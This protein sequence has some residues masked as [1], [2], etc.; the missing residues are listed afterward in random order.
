MSEDVALH[1]EGVGFLF[2][3][4]NSTGD[5]VDLAANEL[6]ATLPAL[7]LGERRLGRTFEGLRLAIG[8]LGL[9]QLVGLFRAQPG[10]GRSG[11]ILDRRSRQWR[12]SWLRFRSGSGGVG[13]GGTRTGDRMVVFAASGGAAWVG[14]LF[15]RLVARRCIETMRNDVPARLARIRHTGSSSD[16]ILRRGR[17]IRT[18]LPYPFFV[19]QGPRLGEPG[20]DFGSRT[21]SE[22]AAHPAQA[23]G[24]IGSTCRAA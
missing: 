20:A 17:V 2:Q 4:A 8:G 14:A 6:L 12:R 7:R 5:R 11:R 22:P 23:V 18:G 16:P 19:L 9:E 3:G 13:D 21:P 1:R 10:Q 15:L 24:L